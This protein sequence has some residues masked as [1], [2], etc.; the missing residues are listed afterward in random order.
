MAQ[1]PRK[2]GGARLRTVRRLTAAAIATVMATAIVVLQP[3]PAGAATASPSDEAW[4]TD[5]IADARRQSGAPALARDAHLDAVARSWAMQL[6]AQQQLAHNPGLGDQVRHHW[7][8]LAENVGEGS[9]AA[10]LHQMF[11]SSSRHRDRML[12]SRS[13]YLGVGAARG[14][15]GRL[16]TAHV[17]MAGSLRECASARDS[18]SRLYRAYFER[19]P[20]R[21][22]SEYWFGQYLTGN[23]LVTIS[24]TF[25]GSDEYRNRYGSLANRAF[26]EMV[27]ENVMERQP[28]RE[29]WD[30]W[31]DKL[32]RH[33][34]PR[35]GV[36]LQFSESPEFVSKTG[37]TSPAPC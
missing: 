25:T 34:L 27:Y 32:D 11:L 18:I 35:G 29:G 2:L 36:M 12:D 31:V 33:V 7:T 22:G 6:A 16:Y 26:V 4:F 37:T 19:S 5:A 13:T 1:V 14:D 9:D 17:F 15:D 24:D 28:D 10:T 23:G 20:D 21:E 3:V 30:Y 8:G